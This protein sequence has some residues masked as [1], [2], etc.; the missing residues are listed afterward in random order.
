MSTWLNK[1]LEAGNIQLENII[2]SKM[3][4]SRRFLPDLLPDYFTGNRKNLF[5]SMIDCWNK[6]GEV[7]PVFLQSTGFENE[8][9][10]ALKEAGSS[11][12]KV[13]A[14]LHTLW[15]QREIAKTVFSAATTYD[16]EDLTPEQIVRRVQEGASKILLKNQDTKYDHHEAVLTLSNLIIKGNETGRETLGYKTGLQEFD[17]YT[18]GIEKGK[19]YAVGALKKTGKSLFSVW[20]SIQLKE[21]GAGVVW[22]SLEMNQT[23]LN[24]CALSNYAEIDSHLLGRK[25]SPENMAKV[26]GSLG[27]L[28]DLDWTI[29]R[30]KSAPELRARLVE[31]QNRKPV[32]VVIVDYIQRMHDID[33]RKD[34][35]REVEALSKAL[36]DMSRELN[37]AMIVLSQLRGEAEKLTDG[38]MPNM[39]YFKESQGI[40]E[41]ADCIITMHNPNRSELP[42]AADGSYQL[43]EISLL[44]EQRYGLSGARFKILVDLRMSK[45]YNHN[46]PYGG[47]K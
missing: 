26:Q 39:S 25:L 9:H 7:D 21:Q 29:I 18:S 40:P 8:I 33:L 10:D 1:F 14:E 42:Y 22:N 15:Q 13:I 45:F 38:E 20:L 30:K 36:A 5:I 37:V 35:V 17:R 28:N 31:L 41:N 27:K 46:D 3:L 19:M 2:L 11:N 23:Q 43:P 47:I 16:D 32:D 34:R 6:T 24:I 12:P 4:V 44:V